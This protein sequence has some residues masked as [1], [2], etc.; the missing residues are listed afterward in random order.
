LAYNTAAVAIAAAINALASVI[1]AGI[2]VTVTN[3]LS[4]VG[5]FTIT[6]TTGTTTT[7]FLCNAASLTPSASSVSFTVIVSTT[8]QTPIIAYMLSVPSHGIADNGNLLLAVSGDTSQFL[9]LNGPK[10]K[11]FDANTIAS[12]TDATYVGKL[13]RAYTPGTDR[14]GTKKTKTFYISGITLGIASPTDIPIPSPL[15]NDAEFLTAAIAA[16]SGYL[17]YDSAALEIWRGPIYA[18]EN[19][20]INMADV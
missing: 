14:L 17:T 3:T 1:S 20:A 12:G 10:W 11:V 2:V 9:Y 18:Q 7:P 5:Q 4:S 6:L 15:L 13:T 8:Q 16:T 19:I